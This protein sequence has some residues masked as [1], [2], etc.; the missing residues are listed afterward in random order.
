M[1]KIKLFLAFVLALAVISGCSVKTAVKNGVLSQNETATDSLEKEP[2]D[3]DEVSKNEEISAVKLQSEDV[4]IKEETEESFAQS[5]GI[6]VDIPENS[7]AEITK[8]IDAE[9]KSENGTKEAQSLCSISVNC[10]EI[11]EKGL[12][13]PEEISLPQSGYILNPSEIS[14]NEGDSVFDILILALT[15]EGI[16]VEYTSSP[17]LNSCYINGIDGIFEFD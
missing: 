8:D 4:S 17:F 10:S 13:T 1:K 16:E 14:F 12:S 6:K 5:E 11:F 2:I 7:V 15:K 3:T 9:S